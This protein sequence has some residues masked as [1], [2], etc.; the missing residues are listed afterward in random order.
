M[1]FSRIILG[2]ALVTLLFVLW[3]EVERRVK[4][5]PGPTAPAFRADLPANAVQ[6][7][8]LTLLA[9]LWFGSL[10]SGGAVLLFLVVGLLA[11]IPARLRNQAGGGLPWKQIVVDLARVVVA[12]VLLQAVLS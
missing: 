12:G 4:Q 6:G 11:E 5:T 3:R 9:G 10:G 8:L 7:L 2:W 1:A